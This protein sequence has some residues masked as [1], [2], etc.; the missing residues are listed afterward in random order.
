METE[1][2]LY[3]PEANA[4]NQFS[5]SATLLPR[6]FNMTHECSPVRSL[7]VCRRYNGT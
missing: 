6:L 4:V 2:R 1:T 7:A 5:D 3:E